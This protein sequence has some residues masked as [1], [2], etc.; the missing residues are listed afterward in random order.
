MPQHQNAW[1]AVQQ[2]E[3]VYNTNKCCSPSE[4][5]TNYIYSTM[6]Y[7]QISTWAAH[8]ICRWCAL[9]RN[10]RAW[11][12]KKLYHRLQSSDIKLIRKLTTSSAESHSKCLSNSKS[13]YEYEQRRTF[14]PDPVTYLPSLVSNVRNPLDK[15]QGKPRIRWLSFG[16]IFYSS[17]T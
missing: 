17:Y 11:G 15:L 5:H 7:G 13:A 6:I 8:T 10:N 16:L 2:E 12:A 3:E 1:S 9:L 14:R 4:F